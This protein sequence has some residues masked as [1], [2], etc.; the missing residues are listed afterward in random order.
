LRANHAYIWLFVLAV[1]LS[2]T[3]VWV[4]SRFNFKKISF[5]CKSLTNVACVASV[6]VEFF[7]FLHVL[8]IFSVWTR[9]YW[10]KKK[11]NSKKREGQGGKGKLALFCLSPNFRGQKAKKK[12]ALKVRKLTRCSYKRLLVLAIGCFWC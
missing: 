9:E 6:S 3:Q 1:A 2:V 7:A 11:E 12:I 4:C 8:D 10:G 5:L